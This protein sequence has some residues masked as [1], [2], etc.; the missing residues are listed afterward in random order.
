MVLRPKKKKSQSKKRSIANY[1]CM[2]YT[3]INKI[4]T[5]HRKIEQSSKNKYQLS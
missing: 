1:S 5:N 4:E 2:G 3:S